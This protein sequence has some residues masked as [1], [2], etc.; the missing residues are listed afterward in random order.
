M[1][2]GL[3]PANVF[4]HTLAFCGKPLILREVSSGLKHVIETIWLEHFVEQAVKRVVQSPGCVQDPAGCQGVLLVDDVDTVLAQRI[5]HTI[6]CC[7]VDDNTTMHALTAFNSVLRDLLQATNV[8]RVSTIIAWPRNQCFD[9]LFSM[10]DWP[11]VDLSAIRR[12]DD[13]GMG[14]SSAEPLMLEC[15]QLRNHFQRAFFLSNVHISESDASH[16]KTRDPVAAVVEALALDATALKDTVLSGD[17]FVKPASNGSSELPPYCCG[18]KDGGL[19]DD[20]HLWSELDVRFACQL[21]L[22]Q[23][24]PSPFKSADKNRAIRKLSVGSCKVDM[25]CRLLMCASQDLRSLST[26]SFCRIYLFSRR[27]GKSSARTPLWRKSFCHDS[28]P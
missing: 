7:C 23:A 17:F 6:R 25:F 28:L 13:V 9:M 3:L 5:D 22:L 21:L 15:T 14:G 10:L 2:V 1:L 11:T 27:F 18:P 12:G 20:S 24:D 4:L 8:L 19:V 26:V 16:F